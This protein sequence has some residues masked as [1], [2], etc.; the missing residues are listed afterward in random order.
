MR[1]RQDLDRLYRIKTAAIWWI[2][3][4]RASQV[5]WHGSTHAPSITLKWLHVFENTRVSRASSASCRTMR[6][7][8]VERD[9]VPTDDVRKWHRRVRIATAPRSSVAAYPPAL[10]SWAC[11][12]YIARMGISVSA[13]HS[14]VVVSYRIGS[15]RIMSVVT[16][17]TKSHNL[18]L[19]VIEYVPHGGDAGQC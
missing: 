6:G 12:V 14:T 8:K 9:E 1:C 2:V 4:K 19:K 10:S 5:G 3:E 17:T 16:L 7:E 13:I 15:D 11:S 18:N